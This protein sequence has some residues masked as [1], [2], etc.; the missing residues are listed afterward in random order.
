[1]HTDLITIGII[2]LL[3]VMSPGPD[4]AI[5]TKNS[6]LGSRRAGYFTTLGIATGIIIHMSY[7]LLGVA[8]LIMH[9]AWLFNG[10]KYLGGGYLVYIGIQSLLHS[11]DKLPQQAGQRH[12]ISDGTAY[13]QGFITNILNPKASLFFLS[14]FTVLVNANTPRVMQVMIAIEI[15]SIA[16]LWFFCLATMITLPRMNQ[17]LAR[18]QRVIS[19]LMGIILITI[20]VVFVLFVER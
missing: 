6:L 17:L 4:F 7:C 16:L 19:I 8:L 11:A 9:S 3:S 14:L 5:V 13:R 1:M 18:S 15:F 10:I 12:Q 20:G 2:M